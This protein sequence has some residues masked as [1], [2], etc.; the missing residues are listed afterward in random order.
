MCHSFY[1]LR[2]GA[3]KYLFD[4]TELLEKHGHEVIPFAMAH[5]MNYP[6]PYSQYFVS[7]IDYP[8]LLKSKTD[9]KTKFKVVE[10]LLYSHESKKNVI[11]LIRDTQPDIAHIHGIGH[12]MS[13]SVL[14]GIESFH[15]PMVMTLHDYG[16]LCP[17]TNFTSDGEI[18]ERC[19]GGRFYNVLLH[20]CK[21]KSYSA[22][23]LAGLTAYND[24]IRKTYERNIDI[25]IAPGKFLMQK[26]VEFGFK[27]EIVQ[28]PNFV[29]LDRFAPNSN[30]SDYYVYA[31]R[32]VYSK[33]L[34]TLIRSSKMIKTARLYIAGDGELK[35]ELENFISDNRL[36]HV[37]LLGHI[38][39]HDLIPLIAGAA[40]TVV[41]SE[42]YENYPLSI[43]ES[44]ACGKPVIASNLGAMPELVKDGWNGLLFEP[45][46]IGQLADRIQFLFDHQ[47]K[48]AEMGMNGRKE[49]DTV[50]HPEVHYQKIMQTYQRALESNRLKN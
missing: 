8:G 44:F 1:Y 10:R 5:E 21:R 26:V 22:S 50:N 2:G 45:G 29:D 6:S 12:E 27:N 9:L 4:L 36:D 40:F 7:N 13:L 11:Q 46:N 47:D 31:G 32:L 16:L 24:S 35:G 34:R 39:P 41:P 19:K 48:A 23:F 15:I 43:I 38:H 3:E 30:T 17:N 42:W 33:G 18:C 20:R 49:V 37:T 14:D 28:I 25:C